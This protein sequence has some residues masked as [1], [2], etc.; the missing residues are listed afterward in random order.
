MFWCVSL[1]FHDIPPFTLLNPTTY[2]FTCGA[3]SGGHLIVKKRNFD[4][5][6]LLAF[7]NPKTDYPSLDDAIR[8]VD[9]IAGLFT[10]REIYS[11]ARATEGTAKEKSAGPDVIHF[12]CHGEFNDRQ[13]LQSALVLTK[14]A[15][16]DGRLQVHEIFELDLKDTNLVA[17]SACE[18][19]VS[20]IQGGDDLVGLSR[21]FIYAGTPSILA[22]LWKVDD[23]ATAELI[24]RFYTNWQVKG[25]NKPKA[26][27]MAQIELKNIPEYK[28]PF[29]WAPFVMIGDWQ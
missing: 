5:K 14:D 17:L 2:F 28:H 18:T 1:L 10:D 27:Q 20:K 4:K 13:P 26:L 22:T 16:N 12:A 9:N 7:A 23:L 15:D 21:G 3:V 25:M 8:E 11:R 24:Q 29:Y 19:G 6:K